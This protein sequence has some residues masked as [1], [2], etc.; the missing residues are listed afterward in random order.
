MRVLRLCS[1]FEPPDSAL[2]GSG[3]T[4]DPV[5]GVQ[6]HTAGL[7]RALDALGVAQTVLT[8]RPPTA[9]VAAPIGRHSRVIRLGHPIGAFRQCYG[10]YAWIHLPRLAAGTDV[11]HAHLGEDL[12]VVPLALRAA[13]LSGAPIVLTVH[14]S[15]R[16][17]LSGDDPRS[18][19]LRTLGGRL[20]GRGV[21]RAAAVIA[22]TERLGRQLSRPGVHVIPSG[23]SGA[24]LAVEPGR[25]LPRDLP[26]PR[27]AF[28]GRLHPQKGVDTLLHA[29]RLLDA[30]YTGYLVIV[31]DGPERARLHRMARHLGIA[32][33]T[34]FLGFVPHDR[35]PS[36]L[37]DVDVLVLPS[38]YEELGSV[39]V[40]AMYCGTPVVASATG[41]IPE[42]VRDGHEGLLVPPGSPAAL[43]GA[44]REVIDDPPLAARLAGHARRRVDEHTWDHLVHRVL[45]V[46]RD[47]CRSVS[48]LRT[49]SDGPLS[50][51]RTTSR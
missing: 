18:L 7:T 31:G 36:L 28:V 17:T 3:V 19:L 22:L 38:R 14:C 48:P 26:H 13:A 5:G 44:L 32:R 43:A 4:Y 15:L 34:R 21:D 20:E 11:V 27:I 6:N 8:S 30:G 9:P 33:R 49:A 35:I 2:T 37:K 50:G 47:V 39:L 1:V 29:F 41:G 10:L 42:L 16:H 23:V 25:G 12:A 51:S 45:D 40:E 46:Y 24:F